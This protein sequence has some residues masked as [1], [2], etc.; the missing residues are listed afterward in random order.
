MTVTEAKQNY[1]QLLDRY[2]NGVAYFERSDVV[3]EEKENH[4]KDFRDILKGLNYLLAK[5]G[6]YTNEEISQGFKM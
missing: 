6:N 3:Q 4:L 1:N 2:N 5:I